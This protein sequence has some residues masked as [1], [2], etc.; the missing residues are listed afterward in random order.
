MKEKYNKV[1]NILT[2]KDL[3][4]LS[5]MFTWNYAALKKANLAH[6]NISDN[7]LKDTVEKAYNLFDDNLNLVLTILQEQGGQ[8]G[9]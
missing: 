7:N 3:D 6:E 4:Y 2:G 1:P 5:D 8:N 9:E